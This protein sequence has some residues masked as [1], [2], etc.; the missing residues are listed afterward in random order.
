MTTLRTQSNNV[1]FP[2]LPP[3]SRNNLSQLVFLLLK[4]LA[5]EALEMKQKMIDLNFAEK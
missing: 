5:L 4:D 3:Y 2:R 1:Y